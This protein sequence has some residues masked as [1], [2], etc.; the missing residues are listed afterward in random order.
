MNIVGNNYSVQELLDMLDRQHLT[1]NREYQRGARLWPAGARSYFIDTILE[2]YP[3]PKLYIYEYV[4]RPFGK[5]TRE[6]V[7]GQQRLLTIVDFVN[8]KFALSGRETKYSGLRFD[9]LDEETRYEFL[10][11]AVSVDVIRSADNDE[12]L[13]MFRRM[14]AYT[15]PLNDAEKRHSQYHGRFKWAINK[16]SSDLDGFFLEFGVFTRRQIVRMADA[17]F[18][19]DCVVAME[20]GV[21]STSPSLL[22]G[23]YKEYDSTFE[24]EDEVF[25]V[26]SE[27][28]GFISE[29]F[30]DLRK[31]HMMKP[32]ALHSL[33]TAM[34]HVRYGIPALAEQLVVDYGDRFCDDSAEASARLLALAQAHEA[35]EEEGP[36]ARYVWGCLGGTNRAPRRAARI[37]AILAALGFG[38]PK[39]IDASLSEKLR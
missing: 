25:G 29:H 36:D 27:V 21:V 7:D 16:L 1:I 11:Y 4:V 19:T 14:N 33:V 13:Q 39:V 18:L 26:F 32:Y 38:T 10:A 12:I 37:Q 20:R 23:V 28:F 9:E 35:K 15:L 6:L 5:L 2:K 24:R 30:F 17:E 3:F 8:G 34:I 22:N 31:S